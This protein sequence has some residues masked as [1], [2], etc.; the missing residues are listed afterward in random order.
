MD[1]EWQ[2]KTLFL[3][4]FDVHSSI[5]FGYCVGVPRSLHIYSSIV[6]LI[7]AVAGKQD[8][9]GTVF[10]LNVVSEYL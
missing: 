1:D 6:L 9:Q 7:A 8:F 2:S 4:S 10:F 5:V 3:T